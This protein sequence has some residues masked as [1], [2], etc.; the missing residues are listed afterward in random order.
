MSDPC[1][2]FLQLKPDE[3]VVLSQ[4]H[5]KQMHK[6]LYSVT[7]NGCR[8]AG[9]SQIWFAYTCGSGGRRN[10]IIILEVCIRA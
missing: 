1:T 10:F 5:K 4:T 3:V 8:T 6:T 9:K 7:A 2:P